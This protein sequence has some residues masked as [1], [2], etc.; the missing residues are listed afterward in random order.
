VCLHVIPQKVRL[1]DS[2]K[3][4]RSVV[5]HH[6]GTGGAVRTRYIAAATDDENR[7][8]TIVALAEH[9]KETKNNS[10]VAHKKN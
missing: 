7:N 1:G 9:N 8:A 5:G 4:P 2:R 3:K 10:T 6:G